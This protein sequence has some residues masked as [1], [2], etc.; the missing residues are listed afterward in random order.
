MSNMRFGK[1]HLRRNLQHFDIKVDVCK[2]YS[3]DLAWM[4]LRSCN[5]DESQVTFLPMAVMGR[6]MCCWVT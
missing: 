4:K 5:G 6:G 2:I 3:R 1:R